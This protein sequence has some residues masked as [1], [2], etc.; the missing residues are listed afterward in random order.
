[1][2]HEIKSIVLTGPAWHGLGHLVGYDHGLTTAEMMDLGGLSG[3]NV[4]KEEVQLAEGYKMVLNRELHIVVKDEVDGGKTVLGWTGKE[5]STFQNEQLFELADSI[6]EVLGEE[7]KGEWDAMGSLK[8]DTIVFGSIRLNNLTIG[9]ED[10]IQQYVLVNTSHD[11]S[12]SIQAS[13][14]NVRTVCWNTLNYA[15]KGVKQTFKMRH[16]S[17]VNGRVQE[18]REALG[19]QAEYSAAFEEEANKL[20]QQPVSTDKFWDIV[21]ELYPVPDKDAAKIAV[22]KW[23]NKTEAIMDIW[24]GDAN[25]PNTIGSIGGTAWGAVNTLAEFTTHYPLTTRANQES[26]LVS[27]S[28]FNAVINAEKNKQLQVVKAFAF[29]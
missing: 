22:T 17:N 16:S 4:H 6:V 19:I 20:F 9:D 11:G 1:M 5:Y 15:L 28:G 7:G 26:L 29:A 12:M 21:C 8:E 18:A 23:S 10:E 3:W 14:T 27:E 13:N 24:K 25:G 2:A